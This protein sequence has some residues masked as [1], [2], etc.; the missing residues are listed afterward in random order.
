MVLYGLNENL[1]SYKSLKKGANFRLSPALRDG[2]NKVP[3]LKLN[4]KS[5]LICK[6]KPPNCVTFP[7]IYL[8]TIWCDMSLSIQFGV[9][10]ATI[11]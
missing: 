9:A 8:E 6:Q 4:A 1:R 5:F 10:M 11:F 7:K 3:T 2:E